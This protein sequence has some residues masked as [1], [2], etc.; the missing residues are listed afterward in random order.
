MGLAL[1]IYTLKS[2]IIVIS[3]IV[4]IYS[5]RHFIFSMNRSIGEQKLYYQ[6]IVD[7]NL[8]MV[9]VIIPMHNAEILAAQSLKTILNSDYPSEKLTRTW[10]A[11][12]YPDHGWGGKNGD[13]TDNTFLRKFE[14]AR[15]EAKQILDNALASIAS[16][17]KAD[18]SKGQPVVVF[19]SLSFRRTDPV[20][21]SLNFEKD[22]ARDIEVVDGSGSKRVCIYF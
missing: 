16:R 11:K 10:E 9:T 19:N 22:Q 18:Q 5:L 1:L 20:A 8:P 6:D 13:I 15:Q 2:Y 12:I 7:T 4:L 14:F 17:V 21:F 3:I